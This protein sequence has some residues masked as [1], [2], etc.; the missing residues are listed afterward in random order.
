M[1]YTGPTGT[2]P[3][4]PIRTAGDLDLGTVQDAAR[5]AS[6]Q[7]SGFET[8]AAGTLGGFVDLVDTFSASVG[9]TDKRENFNKMALRFFDS[10][11]LNDF[12]H[13]TRGAQEIGSA[14]Q[15]VIISDIIAGRITKPASILMRGMSKIPY[16]RR[17]AALDK[18]YDLAMQ[19]VR[20]VDVA[21]ARRGTLGS[22]QYRGIAEVPIG[23][24]DKSTG[25]FKQ[26]LKPVARN[27]AVLTARG[28]GAAKGVR[29]AAAT[30]AVMA[31]TMNQNGFLYDD[32]LAHNLTWMAVGLGV[33]G[34]FDAA[35]TSYRIRKTANSDLIRREFAA[36]LD[37][38]DLESKR[39]LWH[40]KKLTDTDRDVAS[41]LGGVI[42]DRVTALNVEATTL[43]ETAIQSQDQATLRATRES[44]ATQKNQLAF[45]EI[46]KVTTKGISTDGRTRFST[47]TPGVENHLKAAMYRD[48]T[49]TNGVEM[50]GRIPEESSIHKVVESHKARIDEM[51]T[52]L[53]DQLADKS[54]TIEEL[55]QVRF[56]LK[57]LEYES[58]LQPMVL[59]DGELM[60]ISEAESFEGFVEP[61][62]KSTAKE[63]DSARLWEIEAE[64][65]SG[66]LSIDDKLIPYIPSGKSLDDIDHYDMLRLYRL[67]RRVI[68]NLKNSTDPIV[69][70]AKPSWFQLDLAEEI[71]I[72]SNGRAKIQWPEG[73]T[74]ESAQV[75]S[76][77]Q[78]AEAMKKQQVKDEALRLKADKAGTTYEGQL[79]KLRVRYNLPRLT[80]YERGVTGQNQHSVEML[81]RGIAAYGPDKARK[82]T[83]HEVLEA[84]ATH[85]RLGDM[86]PATRDDMRKLHGNSFSFMLDDG[87]HRI[88]PIMM[89][90]RAMNP[91]I[92]WSVDTLAERMAAA[93]MQSLFVLTQATSAPMTRGLATSIINSADFD[94]VA[95]PQE[96]LETQIQGNLIGGSPESVSGAFAKSLVTSEWRDRDSPILLAATRLADSVD[97][98]TRDYMK[99]V[100]E[101]AMGDRLSVL[102]NPRNA[103]TRLLLN[104]FHSYA[105]GWHLQKKT[106]PM[107]GG[108]IGFL[109]EQT[110]ENAER[111]RAING[112]EMGKDEILTNPRG[113]A[114]VLDG[115]GL[116]IQEAFNRITN[117]LVEEKNTLLRAAGRGQIQKKNWY[118]PPQNTQG[119]LIG[120]TIGPDGRAVPG[121]GVVESTQQNF[122]KARADIIK[123]I[124]ENLG[125]GYTFRTQD[126]LKEFADIWD[127][128]DM[129]FIDPGKTAIQP[130]KVSR[131]ALIGP[132]IRV[133][134]FEESL[135]YIRN[136][137]MSHGDDIK[138]HLLKEQIQAAKMRS[139]ITSST[140]RESSGFNQRSKFR[141]VYDYYLENL[142]GTNKLNNEG[143]I[144]GRIYNPIEGFLDKALEGTIPAFRGAQGVWRATDLWVRNKIPGI[145]NDASRRDFEALAKK[146]GDYM[147]FESA[148][149]MAERQTAAKTPLSVQKI[150]GEL[151]R[152][153]AAVVLRMF[154]VAHPVMNLTGMVNAMPSVIRHLRRLP[155]ESQEEWAARIGHSAMMFNVNGESV[156]V[157]DM[158]KIAARGFKR[159][160]SRAAEADYDF[161][162]KRGY[163]SQEVAEFQR[164]FGAIESKGAWEKFFYGDPS[165]KS[166]FNKLTGKAGQSKGVTGWTGILSDRSEDFSRSWGHMVGLE[167]AETLGIKGMEAKHAFAHDIANKMIANYNPHNRPEI[168]QG[169]LGAPIGLFQSF[170]FNYYQ[171]LFR[172]AE[173]KDYQSLAT[174]YGVQGG[175]FGVTSLTGWEQVNSL[176]LEQSKGENDIDAGI[177][178]K[179]GGPGGDLL[180]N[181]ALSNLPKLFGAGGV[182]LYS[183]G[184]TNVRLPGLGGSSIPAFNI[185]AKIWEGV[186]EGL[187]LFKNAHPGITSQQL[188]EIA[189]NMIANRPLAGMIE[190]F[191]AGGYDTD[192][193]GQ[194]VSE[195]Q[196]AAEV[197]YRLLGVRSMRQSKEI[198]AFY[199]D[200]DAQ[201]YQAAAKETLRKASRAAIR[202]ENFDQL[203]TIFEKYLDT[204]GDPRHFRRWIAEN[205]EAATTTR[206]Q[207]KL[208]DLLNNPNNFERVIQLM[209]RGVSITDE[210]ELGDEL[211][212]SYNPDDELNQDTLGLG[213]YSNQYTTE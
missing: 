112:R 48:P 63:G 117:A 88:E 121:Y 211:Y 15:G 115:L 127:K 154:E 187:G 192:R 159:A 60:P 62:I 170:I 26:A 97:R 134:A 7:R 108:K 116:E 136:Q 204:G 191:A 10:P 169:A 83:Y 68:D 184:D 84:V 168:L 100:V 210:E 9:I 141:N 59:M 24:Y 176:F 81:L 201:E 1:P 74:R 34:L 49:V 104:Q 125:I 36:A 19:T 181:G 46:N 95:R 71:L 14:V 114:I 156:G 96:L 92:D 200:K 148:A 193:Y 197:T 208:E 55:E 190:Q 157:V 27:K 144:W 103:E 98:L 129:D 89:Y 123:R 158:T 111:F 41:F 11:G 25:V 76:L 90:K 66:R 155:S 72:A 3:V 195:T 12:Y 179:L 151:N 203:P 75:E 102:S 51:R 91:E 56:R 145:D 113:Q 110:P 199:A 13:D 86:I 58:N 182:D 206:A 189:S 147:P 128:A 2:S 77:V 107:D 119:K 207:R 186:N 160:W 99:Q 40:G 44:L 135:E 161:M 47:K 198:Q 173:T 142:L 202:A 124:D 205:A 65:A 73:M 4:V 183:R 164:Q 69:M 6:T 28:L 133:T 138:R 120:F 175:L 162:V 152:F 178:S 163:L 57:R 82:M 33:G 172:Y 85:K 177:Y 23:I 22:Q 31:L 78:K 50:M 139:A 54:L 101:S 43:R 143:T 35:H 185:V 8:V 118:A 21:L 38:E 70:P 137:F 106:V 32:D 212:D 17:I 166:R 42:A 109:L 150:T 105:N 61:N 94:Q 53:E 194:L 29:H 52:T 180:A 196:G 149:K 67:G 16:V 79:S 171:R 80:A 131:G 5:K 87:G 122:D 130:G 188:A 174:Q 165:Q 30:E 64:A 39:T 213:Q 45:E 153:T 93:K 37:P 167:L 126:E 140:T 132:D 20:D 18:Q 209:D 146:L